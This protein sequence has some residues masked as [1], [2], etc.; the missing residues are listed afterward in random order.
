MSVGNYSL[1]LAG[2]AGVVT[3]VI[4]ISTLLVGLGRETRDV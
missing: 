2:T 3:I 1:A 4:I